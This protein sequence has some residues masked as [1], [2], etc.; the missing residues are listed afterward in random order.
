[1]QVQKRIVLVLKR[2]LKVSIKLINK[3]RAKKQQPYIVVK[4]EPCLLKENAVR[5]LKRRKVPEVSVEP[6]V[7]EV[8]SSVPE[9]VVKPTDVSVEEEPERPTRQVGPTVREL[10][11]II[12]CRKGLQ[13]E[14]LQKHQS[15]KIAALVRVIENIN[16]TPSV[17]IE[18]EDLALEDFFS[19]A[20]V[21][22]LHLDE[23]FAW[24]QV[25]MLHL[26]EFFADA[27]ID[28]LHLDEFFAENEEEQASAKVEQA[29][30]IPRTCSFDTLQTITR[31]S[32]YSHSCPELLMLM[33]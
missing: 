5:C 21:P 14:R 1:M 6:S 18:V 25:P 23:F 4:G 7:P 8:P 31:G 27:E 16:K 3:L 20:V 15:E 24:A 32:P 13:R 22:M 9:V 28:M 12:E 17:E 11:Y 19:W 33:A 10:A 26:D 30:S 2:A 29:K